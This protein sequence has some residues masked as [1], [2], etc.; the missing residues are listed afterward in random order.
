[1]LFDLR[2]RGRRR[3]VQIVY[4][5]LVV[6][7]LVGF[8]GFGVG[9][10]GGSGGSPIEAIFGSKE[11]SAA[12]GY[13]KQVSEAEKRTRKNP[14][15]AA[16]WVQLAEAR[17][18]QASGSEYYDEESQ[19]FTSKGKEKLAKVV[20]A[21][22][23]YVALKPSGPP[24]TITNDMIRV[25]GEEG[26]NQPAEAVAVLQYAIPTRPASVALYGDLAK[27][28][29]QAKNVSVGDLASQKTISL[30]PAAD[31]KKV[32]AELAEIK[33]NPSGNPANQT[34]TSTTNGKV[35]TV[36]VNSKG[37]GTIIKTSAASPTPTKKK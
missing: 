33:A 18:R 14:S 34:Y 32:E 5:G 9:V 16:A 12:S 1:M 6:L 36:K 20:D 25:F 8:V 13:T 17:F 27:Y 19:Q 3:T 35:Y 4:L 28:A 37:Q 24:L 11:G 23:Q 22:N 10:G 29:Y 2:A 26:L 7:F 31:R 15:E 30:T 21:W